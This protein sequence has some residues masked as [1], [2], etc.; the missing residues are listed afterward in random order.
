[1]M[2]SA[3]HPT[4]RPTQHNA[5]VGALTFD[6]FIDNWRRS[7]I[8][9]ANVIPQARNKHT[10][11]RPGNGRTPT[12]WLPKLTLLQQIAGAIEKC[13]GTLSSRIASAA[14]KVYIS[15]SPGGIMFSALSMSSTPER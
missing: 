6:D 14:S 10:R 2:A 9:T 13:D 5:K 15:N 4:L 3:K 11:R 12:F 7:N 8:G 1:M